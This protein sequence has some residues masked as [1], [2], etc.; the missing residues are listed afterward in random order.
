MQLLQRQLAGGLL[1]KAPR[2][3]KH[4]TT[5]SLLQAREHRFAAGGGAHD[6]LRGARVAMR[7]HSDVEVEAAT[8]VQMVVRGW[9]ARAALAARRRIRDELSALCAAEPLLEGRL[10]R[11]QAVARGV[12]VRDAARRQA[13]ERLGRG[14]AAGGGGG[15]G[16]GGARQHHLSPR[17]NAV[18]E[19][20][21]VGRGDGDAG[22]DGAPMV[23]PH[24]SPIALSPMAS[25]RDDALRERGNAREEQGLNGC[26]ARQLERVAPLGGGPVRDAARAQGHEA[27]Q[28]CVERADECRKHALQLLRQVP[29]TLAPAGA[30]G[31]GGGRDGSNNDVEREAAFGVLCEAFGEECVERWWRVCLVC[32]VCLGVRGVG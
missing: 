12:A 2:P 15:G 23:S 30:G 10:V 5:R 14:M 31:G 20:G 18:V 16:D 25:P 29:A 1:S 4:A 17:V 27:R 11:L 26:E 24:L 28:R 7:A 19:E 3:P 32:L 22:G 6:A 8:R 21:V 9:E 13:R